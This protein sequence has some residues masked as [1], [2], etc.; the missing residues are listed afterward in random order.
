MSRVITLSLEA[1]KRLVARAVASLPDVREAASNGIVVLSQGTSCG[2]ILE[3]LAGVSLDISTY[4]CGYISGRGPCNLGPGEQ[5]RLSLV[6]RGRLV[7]MAKKDGIDFTPELREYL[8]RM[9]PRDFFIKGGSIID[10][11]G[12]VAVMV[13][14]RDGGEIGA[15]LPLIKSGRIQSIIPMTVTKTAPVSLD[16]IMDTLRHD[17]ITKTWCDAEPCDIVEMSGRIVTEIEAL[18]ILTGARA[19]PI[20]MNG[21]GSSRGG[22]TLLVSGT[23]EEVRR[24]YDLLSAMKNEPLLRDPKMVKCETCPAYTDLRALPRVQ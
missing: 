23:S 22:V 3:E 5:F 17:P 9:G 18:S 16:E 13:G 14:D 21:V 15:A 19:H 6:V 8:G 12:R 10:R 7:R 20:G 4:A 2:Y 11:D 1:S 24:A